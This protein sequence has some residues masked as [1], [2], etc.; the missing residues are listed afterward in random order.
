MPTVRGP[1]QILD[2]VPH[3]AGINWDAVRVEHSVGHPAARILGPRCGAVVNDPRERA[4]YW[5]VPAGAVNGWSHAGTRA[6]SRGDVVVIPAPRRICGPGP[7]WQVCP[8]VS[9]WITAPEALVA[10]LE[11]SRAR[12]VMQS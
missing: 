12:M 5:F 6:L 2:C 8:G 11:D 10:A 4:L 3:A 7:H 1:S 9:D